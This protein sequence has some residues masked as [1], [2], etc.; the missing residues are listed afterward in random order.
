MR[1]SGRA[2]FEFSGAVEL[3]CRLVGRCEIGRA[4]QKPGDILGEHIQHLARRIASGNS[5]RIRRKARQIAIPAGGQLA[6]LHLID[7][8]GEI[9]EA[10]AVFGKHRF[11][12]APRLA[13]ALA[14]AVGEVLDDSV[15]HQELGVLRPV[16]GA[17]DELHFLFAQGLAMGR[18]GI[19]LVRRAVADVAVEN[20]QR[21]PA[22]GLAEDRERLLDALEIVGIADPQHVPMVAEEAGG[23]VLGKGD[24][25]SCR[26]W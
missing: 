25:W 14:D 13:T 3:Q 26:R 19:D 9:R 24:A 1:P 4:A 18:G 17:L 6:S 5:L 8:G 21:R 10:L 2:G 23:D 16:I 15:R 20:D 22:L 7:L 12:V 11:P